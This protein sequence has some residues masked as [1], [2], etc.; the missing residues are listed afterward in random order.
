MGAARTAT[1]T[2]AG[3]SVSVAQG[4][5]ACSY[6]LSDSSQDV[7]AQGGGVSVNV[8]TAAACA[9]TAV[10][11][12]P[13]IDVNDGSGRTGPGAVN[14]TVDPNT[15]AARTGTVTIAGRTFTVEQAGA[16]TYAI[17]P[18]GVAASAVGGLEIVTVTAPSDCTWTAVSGAPWIAVTQGANGSGN[19]SV[20]LTVEANPDVE[21]TGSV[22]IAGHTFTVT[23]AGA[24]VYSINPSSD[25][26]L[27][28][29][30]EEEVTV[31]A[32]VG[33]AWTAVSNDPWI[34]IEQGGSG[35]GPGTVTLE[36]E[37][38]SGAARTGTAT[39]AGDTYTVTQAASLVDAEDVESGGGE[40]AEI[41]SQPAG[42]NGS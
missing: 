3:Q 22:S 20:T 8:L 26:V 28:S 40:R 29:G 11:A 23:Q 33:C 6:S 4:A 19:A 9:W 41:G 13:W 17:A 36:I 16:C 37:S 18:A 38:N 30:G 27:A 32:L 35:D 24:C 31:S 1:L 2:V 34:V 10:S 15:G 39:I 21:R 5:A 14:M 25:S 12:V 42:G 7:A